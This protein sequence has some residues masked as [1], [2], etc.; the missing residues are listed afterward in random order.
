MMTMFAVGLIMGL[1]I[2]LQIAIYSG[3]RPKDVA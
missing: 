2:G 1:S 3:I